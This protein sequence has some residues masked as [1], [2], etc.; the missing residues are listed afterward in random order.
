MAGR[1]LVAAALA[2][3]LVLGGCAEG[4]KTPPGEL[5]STELTSPWTVSDTA[6]VDTA[7]DDFVL[8][9]EVDKPVTLVFFGYINCP[10]IR[11]IVMSNI[12]SALTRL[13]EQQREQVDVVFVTTDPARDD[14]LVL[15]TYLDRFNPAFVGLT[16]SMQQILELG[17]AFHVAVE[18]GEKLPSGGYDVTH[19]TQ[20]FLVDDQAQIPMF[21]RQ[22]TSAA[23][24]ADDLVQLLED[25]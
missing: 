2:A 5:A 22:D 6:L 4:S 9:D 7:G 12:A 14:E 11:Q 13:D 1:S 18:K 15:R 24:L 20:V 16:G 19:G 17:G 23:D 25:A 3:A 21:W 10:D 8:A